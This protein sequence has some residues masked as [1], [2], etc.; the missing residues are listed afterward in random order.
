MTIQEL[1]SY[2]AGKPPMMEVFV[3]NDDGPDIKFINDIEIDTEG[4]TPVLIFHTSQSEKDYKDPNDYSYDQEIAKK[5][6]EALN[7]DMSK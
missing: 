2:L 4:I 3:F 1:I 5:R 6:Q 7:L